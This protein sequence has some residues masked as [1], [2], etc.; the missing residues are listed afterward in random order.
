MTD[1]TAPSRF[2]HLTETVSTNIDALKLAADGDIGPLWIV[3]DRQTG[4]K[5]RSGRAWVSL[6]GNLHASF[7]IAREVAPEVLPQISLVAAVGVIDAIRAVIPPTVHPD[8][9]LKWP[10]DVMLGGGKIAGLLVE[11]TKLAGRP[12]FAIVI[13]V[14]INIV[15][16]PN[17]ADRVTT[18]LADVAGEMRTRDL[19]LAMLDAHLGAAIQLWNCGANFP[20][21]RA[22]WSERAGSIGE[23]ITIQSRGVSV[24]GFYAGLDDAG[25]LRLRS[26]DGTVAS[27]TWGDVTL[28]SEMTPGTAGQDRIGNDS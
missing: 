17:L 6:D 20:A 26:A 8:L 24:S 18:T 9:R 10:N 7:L 5:G 19:L 11:S 14:G 15:A 2:L 23:A 28:A 4:G 3:A 1:A 12:D 22:A 16:A 21:I 25:A 27:Y 13:G